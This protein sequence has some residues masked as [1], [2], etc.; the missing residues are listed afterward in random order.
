MT[1]PSVDQPPVTQPAVTGSPVAQTPVAGSLVT[2]PA[3]PVSPVAGTPVTGERA[4]GLPPPAASPGPGLRAAG[5]LSPA[6]PAEAGT[7]GVTQPGTGLAGPLPARD[8]AAVP[9]RGGS[10]GPATL[11]GGRPGTGSPGGARAPARPGDLAGPGPAAGPLA[12]VTAGGGVAAARRVAAGA[13]WVRGGDGWYVPGHGGVLEAGRGGGGEGGVVGVPAGSRGVFDGSGELVHVVLPGGVSFERDLAGAWSPARSGP[14]EV[15]VVKTGGPVR[16]VSGDGSGVVSLPGESEEVADRGVVVAYRQVRAADGSRLAEPRVFLRD[17]GGWAEAGAGV[18]PAAYEGWLAA[19]NQAHEAA[20]TLQ[21]IAARGGLAGLPDEGVRG[22]LRG[23]ADDAVAAVYEWV[24]RTRGVALRWTQLA[25]SHALAG[26]DVV[27]M[28]AGEGKSWLFLVDAAR[29]AVRPGVDAVHVITTRQ[30]LADREF[31]EYTAVLGGLGFDVRRM[32]PDREVEAPAAGRP[33]IYVGTSQDVGFTKLRTGLVPGQDKAVPLLR[34]DAGVDEVDEAFVYSDS[35][36]ILSEGVQGAAPDVVLGPVGQAARVITGGLASGEL[37]AADFGRAEGQVGGA[38]ALTAG[39]HGRAAALLGITVGDDGRLDGDLVRRL[40]MAAAAHFEYAENVHYVLHDGKAFIIDQTTHEVLFNPE[41]ATES[42]WNGGLAQAI[43]AKHGLTVRDD[44]ATSKSVSARELYTHPVYRRVTGASGTAAG[45]GARFAEAGLSS[46]VTSIPRYYASRLATAADHVSPGLAAKLDT[47]AAD[48]AAMAAGSKNQPQLIL[49]H[50]NDLVAQLSERLH[51]LGVDHKA[52]DAKWFL[53]QGTG[54]ETAF[55]DIIENAGRPGQVLVINMQG[56]RG[57][58]IPLTP[59]ARELGG[60]HV[61]ITARS[62]LSADIDIQA[63]NRAARSGDPGSVNYYISPDD[64]AFA[65]SPNPDVH[66]AIIKYT[67]ARTTTTQDTDTPDP[68]TTDGA[69]AG[70]PDTTAAPAAIPEPVRA[71]HQAELA[72]AEQALRDL[73]P[74]LQADAATRHGL[75]DPA[76]PNAPPAPGTAAA[77]TATTP[78]AATPPPPQPPPA[79]PSAPPALGS[80][81]PVGRTVADRQARSATRQQLRRYHARQPAPDALTAGGGPGPA[82]G[83]PAATGK[84]VLATGPQVMAAGGEAAGGEFGYRSDGVPRVLRS[85]ALGRA[86]GPVAPED[87]ESAQPGPVTGQRPIAWSSGPYPGPG[88]G[89]GPAEQG[90]RGGV[91]SIDVSSPDAPQALALLAAAPEL[92]GLPGQGLEGPGLDDVGLLDRAWRKLTDE[93]RLR[94][95]VDQAQKL[96]GRRELVAAVMTGTSIGVLRPQDQAVRWLALQLYH[97]QVGRAGAQVLAT[98]LAAHLAEVLGPPRPGGPDGEPAGAGRWQGP[99]RAEIARAEIARVAARLAGDGGDGRAEE[100]ADA[101]ARYGRARAARAAAVAALAVFLGRLGGGSGPLEGEQR[102]RAGVRVA[103]RE[104]T[105]AGEELAAL[106]VAYPER[107]WRKLERVLARQGS[108]ALPGGGPGRGAAAGAG[109]GRAGLARAGA[110]GAAG[111][112][113]LGKR[114]RGEEEAGAEAGPSQRPRVAELPGGPGAVLAAGGAVPVG[115]AVAYLSGDPAADLDAGQLREVVKALASGLTV[116]PTTQAL[117]LALALLQAADDSV[118][119]TMFADPGLAA[120]LEAAFAPGEGAVG[121]LRAELER[122]YTWR[123]G[124]GAPEAVAAGTAQPLV[125]Y[126]AREFSPGLIDPELAGLSVTD[127]MTAEQARTVLFGRDRDQMLRYVLAWLPPVQS[128]RAEW[129]VRRGREAAGWADLARRRLAGDPAVRPSAGGLWELV[130]GLVTGLPSADERW[131]AVH[132]LR[133]AGSSDLKAAFHEGGQLLEMLDESIPAGDGLR[134]ALDDVL[135]ERFINGRAWLRQEQL[136]TPGAEGLAVWTRGQAGAGAVRSGEAALTA[137]GPALA[138]SLESAWLVGR[139]ELTE[140]AARLAE[141]AVASGLGDAAEA[142]SEALATYE[143]A[144]RNRSKAVQALAEFRSRPGDRSTPLPGEPQQLLDVR[145]A[146]D[147]L[148]Q[149]A[150]ALV[151]LEVNPSRASRSLARVLARQVGGGVPGGAPGGARGGGAAAGTKRRAGGLDEQVAQR[152][153]HRAAARGEDQAM[154]ESQP[155]PGRLPLLTPGISASDTRASDAMEVDDEGGPRGA[156]VRPVSAFAPEWAR[157]GP[158]FFTVPEPE[159][160]RRLEDLRI[161]RE[162]VREQLERTARRHA[163]TA[164]EVRN[165]PGGNMAAPSAQGVYEPGGAGFLVTV[166]VPYRPDPG[167]YDAEYRSPAELVEMFVRAAGPRAASG[168]RMVIAINRFNDPRRRGVKWTGGL[169]YGTTDLLEGELAEAVEFWQRRVDAVAPGVASVIGQM[170]EPSLWDGDRL[171]DPDV[172]RHLMMSGY[173]R[174]WRRFPYAGVR[175][176]M[177]GSAEALARLREL[178][179]FNDEVWIHLGDSDVID[180][181]NPA[182]GNKLSLLGRYAAEIRGS[183]VDGPSPLVRLGGGYA[184]SPVELE[185]GPRRGPADGETARLGDAARLTLL[186]VEADQQQRDIMSRGR[187]PRGYFT[188]QNTLLNSRYVER[189]IGAMGQDVANAL[190]MPDLFLGLHARLGKLGLL[191]DE[192]SRFLADPAARVLT[193]AHGMRTT[194]GPEDMRDVLLPRTGEA[195]Q[196]TGFEVL[197]PGRTLREFGILATDGIR[198]KDRNLTFRPLQFLRVGKALGLS[199]ER[200]MFDPDARPRALASRLRLLRKAPAGTA[201][202]R[203]RAHLLDTGPKAAAAAQ[204]T[205][206]FEGVLARRWTEPL[207]DLLA[208]LAQY[209]SEPLP[210]WYATEFARLPEIDPTDLELA[211]ALTRLQ[212]AGAQDEASL[213]EASL[214]EAA[215]NEAT[216]T[217]PAARGE[218]AA[219]EAGRPGEPGAAAG[220]VVDDMT[221]VLRMFT[222]LTLDTGQGPEPVPG[223]AVAR[224]RLAPAAGELASWPGERGVLA[225]YPELARAPELVRRMQVVNVAA[226][227][228][229]RELSAERRASYQR[230]RG[231]LIG[232]GRVIPV[233]AGGDG[234]FGSLLVMAGPYLRHWGITRGMPWGGREPSVAQLRAAVARALAADFDDYRRS[235]GAGGGQRHGM[236]VGRFPDLM[237]LERD[238]FAQRDLLA[239][240]MKWIQTP[241][242]WTGDTGDLMVAIAADLWRLPLTSLGPENPRDFGPADAG[243]ARGY[244]LFDGVHYTGLAHDAADPARSAAELLALPAEPGFQIPAGIGGR[245]LAGQFADA[246]GDL[247]RVVVEA[248]DRAPGSEQA[249]LHARLA[250]LSSEFADAAGRAGVTADEAVLGEQIRR[251][252]VRYHDLS[253]VLR[254]IRSLDSDGDGPDFDDDGEVGAVVPVPAGP[255]ADTSSPGFAAAVSELAARLYGEQEPPVPLHE[256]M[257]DLVD[258]GWIQEVPSAGGL[259]AVVADLYDLPVGEVSPAVVDDALRHLARIVAQ[260]RQD[261]AAVPRPAGRERPRAE[262]GQA[263]AAERRGPGEQEPGEAGEPAAVDGSAGGAVVPG[264][265][266]AAAAAAAAAVA[267]PLGRL[268]P[269]QLAGLLRDERAAA[270]VPG[271][272]QDGTPAHE[273][274]QRAR[275]K[276][277]QALA[278]LP[279]DLARK[280]P[281][282]TPGPARSA[283]A[284]AAIATIIG[285]WRD[286]RYQPLGAVTRSQH[287]QAALWLRESPK[288]PPMLAEVLWVTGLIDARELAY[289]AGPAGGGQPRIGLASELARRLEAEQVAY[290]AAVGGGREEPGS[291]PAVQRARDAVDTLDLAR[292][293]DLTGKG[294]GTPAQAIRALIAL[295]RLQEYPRKLEVPKA[296]NKQAYEWLLSR[297]AGMPRVV[298][299]ALLVLGAIDEVDFEY[300]TGPV[301]EDRS[302]GGLLTPGWPGLLMAAEKAARAAYRTAAA[303]DTDGAAAAAAAKAAWEQARADVDAAQADPALENL[304]NTTN[305]GTSS[306]K[307]AAAARL[308]VII[309]LWRE[310]GYPDEGLRISATKETNATYKWAMS[311]GRGTARLVAEMLLAAGVITRRD[312]EYYVGEGAGGGRRFGGLLAPQGLGSGMEEERAA[313]AA[314]RRA[315]QQGPAVQDARRVVDAALAGLPEQFRGSLAFGDVALNATTQLISLWRVQGYPRRVVI[316]KSGQLYTQLYQWAR[317]RG[318]ER[319]R[320]VAE[321]LLVMG[322]IDERDFARLI[323]RSAVTV[324]RQGSGGAGSGDHHLR[325]R[326]LVP[327]GPGADTSSHGFAAAVSELEG[328]LYGEQEPPVPLYEVMAY[329]VDEGRIQAVPSAD[330]LRA[331]VADLYGMPVG[332]VSLDVVDEALRKLAHI[333]AQARQAG[334]ARPALTG[335]RSPLAWPSPVKPTPAA[336]SALAGPASVPVAALPGLAAA[337]PGR[338]RGDAVRAGNA[339]PGQVAARLLDSAWGKLR[340][341]ARVEAAVGRAQQL[342]GRPEPVI[343]VRTQTPTAELDPLGQAIRWLA[344][345]LYRNPGDRASAQA[346]ARDLA[347]RLDEVL[348]LPRPGLP[349]GVR[350]PAGPG[351]SSGQAPGG[352]AGGDGVAPGPGAED[353]VV[354]AS[355]VAAVARG[356][357]SAVRL[358]GVGVERL[359]VRL[360]LAGG[361]EPARGEVLLR[362]GGGLVSVAGGA[363]RAW[364]GEDFRLYESRAVRQA[365]GV[366]PLAPEMFADSSVSVVVPVVSVPWRGLADPGG[367]AAA[368]GLLREV[369]EQFG[370]APAARGAPEEAGTAVDDSVSLAGL[371]GGLPYVDSDGPRGGV[372]V[373]R[374][375]SLPGGVPLRVRLSVGVPLGGGVLAALAG[376][377]DGL[378][379]ESAGAGVLDAALRFGWRVARRFAVAVPGG[380]AAGDARPAGGWDVGDAVTTAEIMALAFV[381]LSGI[382]AVGTAVLGEAAVMPVAVGQPLAEIVAGLGPRLRT[383]LAGD[384]NFILVTIGESLVQWF[385]QAG[386]RLAALLGRLAVEI[387]SGG[388]GGLE[389]VVASGSGVAGSGSAGRPGGAGGLVVLEVVHGGRGGPGMSTGAGTAGVSGGLVLGVAAEAVRGMSGVAR[390]AGMVAG[391]P[392]LLGE[393]VEGRVVAARLRYAVVSGE[394]DRGAEAGRLLGEAAGWY[395]GRFPEAGEALGVLLGLVAAGAGVQGLPGDGGVRGAG[396]VAPGVWSAEW[397]RAADRYEAAY[398][399]VVRGG[400]GEVALPRGAVRGMVAELAGLAGGGGVEFMPEVLG[401]EEVAAGLDA[402]AGLLGGAASGRGGGAVLAV[403]VN[404]LLLMASLV[405]VRA[406]RAA[407]LVNAGWLGYLL[408]Q[409]GEALAPGGDSLADPLE[410][411]LAGTGYR[412]DDRLGKRLARLALLNLTE[413]VR[414]QVAA[415]PLFGLLLDSPLLGEA[416]FGAGGAPEQFFRNTGAVAAVDRVLAGRVPT[417]AGLLVVGRNVE[418]WLRDRAGQLPAGGGVLGEADQAGLGPLRAPRTIGELVQSRIAEAADQLADIEADAAAVLGLGNREVAGARLR[419]LTARWARA[420]HKLGG[421]AAVAGESG[422]PQVPVLTRT[423]AASVV[424]RAADRGARRAAGVDLD[425]YLAPVNE[426]LSWPVAAPSRVLA[427]W[428]GSDQARVRFWKLVRAEGVI[429][430]R[431]GPGGGRLVVVRAVRGD[432]G[433]AVAFAD[434]GLPGEQVV[435]LAQIS[436]WARSRAV[437]VHQAYLPAGPA[438]A[439]PAAEPAAGNLA[440]RDLAAGGPPELLA[441]AWRAAE[442]VVLYLAGDLGQDLDGAA[443]Q[444]A[445]VLAL[446]EGPPVAGGGFRRRALML[447][448]AADNRM[449]GRLFGD[450]GLLLGVLSA[451]IPAGDSLRD[452]LDGFISERFGGGWPA[453]ASGTVHPQGQPALPFS[454]GLLSARLAGADLAGPLTE[455]EAGRVISALAQAS[456]EQMI[457]LLGRLLAAERARAT[458]WLLA[459]RAEIGSRAAPGGPGDNQQALAVLEEALAWAYHDAAARVPDIPALRLLTLIPPEDNVTALRAAISPPAAGPPAHDAP[460]GTSTDDSSYESADPDDYWIAGTSDEGTDAAGVAA[461]PASADDDL[462]E[463]IDAGGYS[464]A[465]A[466]PED[467]S[468][469]GTSGVASETHQTSAKEMFRTALRNAYALSISRLHQ[470][471]VVGNGPE[472]RLARGLHSMDDIGEIARWAKR[473]IDDQFGRFATAPPLL[474]GWPERPI[475]HDQFAYVGTQIEAHRNDADWRR[476]YAAEELREHLYSQPGLLRVMAEYES[477]PDF[478]LEGQPLN[479]DARIVRAVIQEILGEP[480]RVDQVLEVRRGWPGKAKPATREVWIQTIRAPDVAGNQFFLWDTAQRL[481]HEYLHLLEHPAYRGYRS[482]L[483]SAAG[484]TLLDGVVSLLTEIVWSGVSL[485]V[486]EPGLRQVI[487]GAYASEPPL[488]PAA[489]PSIARQRHASY[490]EVM[491]LLHVVGSVRN[492]YAAFFLGDVEKI[493]GPVGLAVLGLPQ[494]PGELAEG[495]RWPDVPSPEERAGLRVGSYVED[496][497]PEQVGDLV[498][499]PGGQVVSVWSHGTSQGPSVAAVP[500]AWGAAGAEGSG[501][502]TGA[503]PEGGAIT[504]ST[505]SPEPVVTRSGFYLPSGPASGDARDLDEVAANW[506]PPVA[507][508]VVWHLHLDPAKGGVPAGD[509]V[510]APEQFY[511]QVMADRRWPAGTLLVII[512]CKAA[513][514]PAA[515]ESAAQALAR[516][517]GGRVLAADGYVW[518]TTDGRVVAAQPAVDGEGRPALDV[519]AGNWVLVEPDGRRSEGLGA[520]LLDILRDGTVTSSLPG[521]EIMVDQPGNQSAEDLRGDQSTVGRQYPRPTQDIRWS[522]PDASPEPSPEASSGPSPVVS[523]EASSGPSPVVSPEASSGPSPVVS[524]EASSRPS[525]QSS[526]EASSRPSPLSSALSSPR[527]T[528]RHSLVSYAPRTVLPTEH[529]DSLLARLTQVLSSSPEPNLSAPWYLRGGETYALGDTEIMGVTRP[530]NV[531]DHVHRVVEQLRTALA[532]PETGQADGPQQ[533]EISDALV[534]RVWASLFEALDSSDTEQWEKYL[535]FGLTLAEGSTLVRVWFR[536]AEGVPGSG[537]ARSRC[538]AQ[539]LPDCLRRHEC[540]SD[541][542]HAHEH[543]PRCARRLHRVRAA[544][545]EFCRAHRTCLPPGHAGEHSRSSRR[546]AIGQPAVQFTPLSPRSW[547]ADQGSCH[548]SRGGH[549]RDDLPG[550]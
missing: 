190:D 164:W 537:P 185:Y 248:A 103:Q 43:E 298:G 451:R 271:A 235:L 410:V 196:I 8:E 500:A 71:G 441:R 32:N 147:E 463:G 223:S 38:A 204:L 184:F 312:F 351:P 438:A 202:D 159:R 436:G 486:G 376:W 209:G 494:A 356:W 505:A 471:L 375:E 539:Q 200:L 226:L 445:A 371:F 221:E 68:D 450:G 509:Q 504:W 480:E 27:N 170:V 154:A 166:P 106:G 273:A 520:S 231:G 237:L 330:G 310:R 206:R 60:M 383:F 188:E 126:P 77:G 35:R 475:I 250:T 483:G 149:A 118:V 138:H 127:A 267:A 193:S 228:E 461:V 124:A 425:D 162:Q 247:H 427:G 15:I 132:L 380:A 194:I 119:G 259:P 398:A 359:G 306:G 442:R 513:A 510:L 301:S 195:G 205:T 316:S 252:S 66:T 511:D 402:I 25:G 257:A 203:V 541:D 161:S 245:A 144:R 212:I 341:S 224:A 354:V 290:D 457:R 387:G 163:M 392:G 39:A 130:T 440:A 5:E 198:R 506:F 112:A 439:E 437:L 274:W 50:R 177:V 110:S 363:A 168:L 79:P 213:D 95:A 431:A 526:P 508:A 416:L 403:V 242:S 266:A 37:T 365:A 487:E 370:R 288:K 484:N 80:A 222:S 280:H 151:A 167:G 455:P 337:R 76:Q 409:I 114:G 462:D 90:G 21:D 208:A 1:G 152:K 318:V 18:H 404:D 328:Q 334:P 422:S 63:Q 214:G 364:P 6:D 134:R 4:L 40:N 236:Y 313:F 26:G 122:F 181:V 125:V 324:P 31:K 335:G 51:G 84:S 83:E 258:E 187:W 304:L 291:D 284:A 413:G 121:Q 69:P 217:A 347:A 233:A 12:P 464:L 94:E 294:S 350:P 282:T 452:E 519:A 430:A 96:I 406:G 355:E 534:S 28:A 405:P 525:P 399:E 550:W 225:D 481:V 285:L 183:A 492:L 128:A 522:S 276:A 174:H 327:A 426:H 89:S 466:S 326:G 135:K 277:S 419:V 2:Q 336:R 9:G 115:R 49:A 401:S 145:Q 264:T 216:L 353:L 275:D 59:G 501:A 81:Q 538:R 331:V 254:Q 515:R 299:E 165:L 97:H 99:G 92:K 374:Y 75:H 393:S 491:K 309:S 46:R 20:R 146:Q 102:L 297:R 434:P 210:Y 408:E 153:R 109:R 143:G 158:G 218:A 173:M 82:V 362:E 101:L 136:R 465:G 22:L 207:D 10:G 493:T 548:L 270:A 72:R 286:R 296:G 255:G 295:W 499:Q 528:R 329:L 346:L 418:A 62:G 460:A 361:R 100:M 47:I 7:A 24:R 308:R 314:A 421:V 55:R 16:L 42:R 443:Q 352:R 476:R 263:R 56:A 485:R 261:A 139:Q 260:A 48:T 108:G 447:L 111:T 415:D 544:P 521:H 86:P 87:N 305:P 424:L 239:R 70:A 332:Q 142:V 88:S 192:H 249:G 448:E 283:A 64:D 343:G 307:A 325:N 340:D 517:G 549:R 545:P 160:V 191:S 496:A 171:V 469:E 199:P 197:R 342:I 186:L 358:E 381:Q 366:G 311:Q 345:Q 292:A 369:V 155:R 446:L 137:P 459:A 41:T 535:R 497:Q 467:A 536:L 390:R 488:D 360:F 495:V 300:F 238:E 435:P 3:V 472:D 322:V 243:G 482:G 117:A 432:S 388:E 131:L 19:A 78:P 503:V 429:L 320:A 530:R 333:V 180:T 98:R 116:M 150:A 502:V 253:D 514:A 527:S 368:L 348:S 411:V 129:W 507:G 176:A 321:A 453:L 470:E 52:I 302:T 30:N 479:D 251:M 107:A 357:G 477:S 524:P 265:A 272:D 256:V 414:E 14:G 531:Y 444:H 57:V 201:A 178:W 74:R 533:V 389:G 120:A 33:T 148:E 13:V 268:A 543:W 468:D 105:W 516:R 420:M 279:G 232:G 407:G 395:L 17:G 34:F 319:P 156:D 382:L 323:A 11:G 547:R 73:I 211:Q 287:S 379:A 338:G 244:L 91:R 489:M 234:F 391:L 179:Q 394:R 339:G 29:Q 140:L 423:G 512:A 385:P 93:T 317:D 498:S 400:A 53:Q 262:D 241:G 54:R 281:V 372:R 220:A 373:A 456:P 367:A 315:G 141:R 219:A 529:S 58:D 349:G 378:D 123:F 169:P 246:F 189:L 377:R 85:G 227:R 289:R 45:K 454:P 175:Q 67:S 473:E 269:G 474:P 36:Y 386:Q 396:P 240:Y 540:G 523:P 412:A 344:L 532:H 490:A 518:T 384:A 458:R 546:G 65:L 182:G 293:L 397:A 449:L 278:R 229:F 23:S 542:E 230:Y 61:R 433:R 44:P 133:A 104:V 478:G 172:L 215:L 303:A 113:G 428:L 417:I 157:W